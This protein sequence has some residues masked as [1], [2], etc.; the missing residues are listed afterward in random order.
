VKQLSKLDLG[1][2]LPYLVN[3]V[4]T[5]IA[6]QFGAEALAPHRLSIAMWRVMAALAAKGSQRQIDVVDLTSIE[7]ST[8]SR[9]VSRLIRMG[10]VTRTRAANSNRE[11]AVELSAKGVA[12]VSRLIPIALA[13]EQAAIAGLSRE[14]TLVL[15]RCLRR[16]YGNMKSRSAISMAPVTYRTP[17]RGRH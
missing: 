13:Y 12:L 6:D 3:R 1:D 14:E 2:Y 10:L 4:G 7:A 9:L 16:V 15:K 17:S 5:I 8:L 11:V